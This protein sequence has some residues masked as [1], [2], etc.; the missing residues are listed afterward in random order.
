MRPHACFHGVWSTSW[1]LF[2]NVD[3]DTAITII[4]QTDWQV[5]GANLVS[6][7]SLLGMF[8]LFESRRASLGKAKLGLP[9]V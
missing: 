4:S 7:N 3:D 6:F 8:R 5:F 2:R 1:I 9:L